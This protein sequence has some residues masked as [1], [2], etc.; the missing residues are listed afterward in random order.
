MT[1]CHSL[2]CVRERRLA[3]SL[4]R[5]PWP[6]TNDHPPGRRWF[7]VARDWKHWGTVFSGQIFNW[8]LILAS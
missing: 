2:P 6:D 8:P 5:P 7:C 1:A 4:G 3:L